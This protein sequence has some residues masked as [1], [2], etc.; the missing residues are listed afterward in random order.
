MVKMLISNF[1]SFP[2]QK[3]KNGQ[4]IIHEEVTQAKKF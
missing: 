4:H 3:N 2:R 1:Y